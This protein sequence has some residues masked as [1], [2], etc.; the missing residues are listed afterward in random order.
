MKS[1]RRLT[2]QCVLSPWPWEQAR[3]VIEDDAEKLWIRSELEGE[4]S[5]NHRLAATCVSGFANRYHR[6]EEP[7][8]TWNMGRP[9]RNLSLSYCSDE[10]ELHRV[11]RRC[12][13]QMGRDVK[14]L[15]REKLWTSTSM[16]MWNR[17]LCCSSYGWKS[18]NILMISRDLY[19]EIKQNPELIVT[20]PWLFPSYLLLGTNR[21]LC[22]NICEWVVYFKNRQKL[23]VVMIKRCDLFRVFLYIHDYAKVSLLFIGTWGPTMLHY[24][25]IKKCN[26]FS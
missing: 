3:Q 7:A 5:W 4:I 19:T 6:A 14:N 17:S 2:A 8:V 18:T 15:R 23:L 20:G 11:C 22:Q 13:Q 1:Y 9:R 21:R 10:G 16:E 24:K 25:N 12:H 26:V